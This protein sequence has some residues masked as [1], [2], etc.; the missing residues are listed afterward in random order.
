MKK[1]LATIFVLVTVIAMA[2]SAKA[3]EASYIHYGVSGCK[4][5][6][7]TGYYMFLQANGSLGTSTFAEDISWSDYKKRGYLF[8]GSEENIDMTIG[9]GYYLITA[10]LGVQGGV[11]LPSDVNEVYYMGGV[12]LDYNVLRPLWEKAKG[13]IDTIAK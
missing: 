6:G 5:E 10:G 12:Y 11:Y 4:I 7:K 2:S 1:I 8:I 3:E 9:L 13:I